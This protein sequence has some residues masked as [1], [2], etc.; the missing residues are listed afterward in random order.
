MQ[1]FSMTPTHHKPNPSYSTPTQVYLTHSKY[2]NFP[3]LK[4]HITLCVLRWLV[5]SPIFHCNVKPLPTLT[6][7]TKSL[8]SMRNA[9]LNRHLPVHLP[10]VHL[11]HHQNGIHLRTES[12]HPTPWTPYQCHQP[13]TLRIPPLTSILDHNHRWLFV[14]HP[15]LFHLYVQRSLPR[16]LPLP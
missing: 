10:T 3:S 13:L 1:K 6:T 15:P 9:P 7:E 11:E 2:D 12:T 5:S 14:H 4:H 16:Y 8:R